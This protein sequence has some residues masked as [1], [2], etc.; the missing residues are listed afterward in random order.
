MQVRLELPDVPPARRTSN[1]PEDSESL[2]VS[3]D[4]GL[5]LL[6]PTGRIRTCAPASGGHVLLCNHPVIT[7]ASCAVLISALESRWGGPSTKRELTSG[8]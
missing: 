8:A 1:T 3:P 4:G 5:A 6:H 2:L 7:R